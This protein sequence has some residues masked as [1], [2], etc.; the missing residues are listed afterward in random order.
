MV[1][2]HSI[3]IPE[4]VALLQLMVSRQSGLPKALTPTQWRLFLLTLLQKQMTSLDPPSGAIVLVA[5]MDA[6]F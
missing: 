2:L 4:D 3:W 6:D 5:S 1:G